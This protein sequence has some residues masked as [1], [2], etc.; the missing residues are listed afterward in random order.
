MLD[1]SLAPGLIVFYLPDILFSLSFVLL[2]IR[3]NNYKKAQTS[4]GVHIVFD[5]NH[6]RKSTVYPFQG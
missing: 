2:C 1:L 4:N 3:L 5:L 6:G